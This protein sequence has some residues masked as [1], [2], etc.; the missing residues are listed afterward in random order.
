MK[1]IF[2]IVDCDSLNRT[3]KPELKFK[4]RDLTPAQTSN[5]FGSTSGY[6]I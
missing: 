2:R 6:N 3:A 1:C 4:A 5:V